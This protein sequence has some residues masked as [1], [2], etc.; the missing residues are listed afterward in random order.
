MA[1]VEDDRVNQAGSEIYLTGNL[2][3]APHPVGIAQIAIDCRIV[4]RRGQARLK[5]AD[6]P[7]VVTGLEISI[8]DGNPLGKEGA[9][10]QMTLLD[11]GD[12]FMK[13]W[14]IDVDF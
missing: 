6:R 2:P 8:A 3:V 14:V 12:D 4:R 13:E 7:I 9:I 5:G 11:R 10:R 1:P